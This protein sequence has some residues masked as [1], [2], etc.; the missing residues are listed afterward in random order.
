M[1]ALKT[2]VDRN[3]NSHC[4][5]DFDRSESYDYR[6]KKVADQLE[7]EIPHVVDP[8]FSQRGGPICEDE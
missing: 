4:W 3:V 2:K 6:V 1:V 5:E 7:K 8:H